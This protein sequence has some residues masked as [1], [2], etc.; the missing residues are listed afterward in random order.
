MLTKSSKQLEIFLNIRTTCKN[1]LFSIILIPVTN[2]GIFFD[3]EYS[4]LTPNKVLIEKDITVQVASSASP[5][6][7]K[8]DPARPIKEIKASGVISIQEKITLN[9]E[10]SYFQ[11]GVIYQGDY[12]PNFIT[13]KFLPEWLLKVLDMNK[14]VGIGQIDFHEASYP[15][16][17]VDREDSIRS[18]KMTFKTQGMVDSNGKFQLS[19]KPRKENIIGLWLRSDGDDSKAKFSVKVTSLILN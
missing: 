17:E 12:R 19:I 9:Q 16:E 5:L 3:L 11:L 18:I 1:V 10:D 14:D 4:K 7:V 6:F 13:K 8:I 2:T 15:G